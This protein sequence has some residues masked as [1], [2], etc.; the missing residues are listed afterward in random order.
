MNHNSTASNSP[1][2]HGPTVGRWKKMVSTVSIAVGVATL[3]NS[4]AAVLTQPFSFVVLYDNSN[5]KNN[6][7]AL[8]RH[9][10]K[11]VACAS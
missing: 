11:K 6:N 10:I 5:H 8:Y 3:E 2:L 7:Y 4:D 9:D 1:H